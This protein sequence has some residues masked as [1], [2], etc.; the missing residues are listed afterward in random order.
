MDTNEL[1]AEESMNEQTPLLKEEII[2]QDTA[3][4][5][6]P[7]EEHVE[8]EEDQTENFNGLSKLELVTI[9]DGFLSESDY[10]VIKS[11]I[12]PVKDAFN[13]L[14]AHEKEKQFEKYLEAGGE[15][16]N[17]L[18]SSNIFVFLT[19]CFLVVEFYKIYFYSQCS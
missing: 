5:I 1:K 12:N 13:D 9:I 17:S 15:K 14:I 6:P 19:T 11:K 8:V 4:D 3:L 16:E 10:N 18:L 7:T 2:I